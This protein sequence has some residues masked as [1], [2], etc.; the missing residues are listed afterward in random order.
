MSVQLVSKISNLYGPDP[1]TLQ[2]DGQ[3]D[4]QTDDMRSQYRANDVDNK[5]NVKKTD[6]DRINEKKSV[7]KIGWSIR[8]GISFPMFCVHTLYQ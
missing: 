6:V 2:T 4:G 1:P 3:T 8:W 7:S 5:M